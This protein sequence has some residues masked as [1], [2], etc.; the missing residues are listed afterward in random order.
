MTIDINTIGA[1]IGAIADAASIATA[2]VG[3]ARAFTAIARR[4]N[5]AR[6]TRRSRAARTART[7]RRSARRARRDRRDPSGGNSR[8][9]LRVAGGPSRSMTHMPYDRKAA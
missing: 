3:T 5:A 2:I 6:T 7:A 8:D 1:W 4:R 9:H